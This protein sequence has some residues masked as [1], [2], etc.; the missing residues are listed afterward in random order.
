MMLLFGV[1]IFSYF[2]GIFI[3]VIEKSKASAAD[4]DNLELLS[5]FFGLIKHFNKDKPMENSFKM[6]IE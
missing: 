2:M 6:Q 1:A 5:K 3:A 4:L